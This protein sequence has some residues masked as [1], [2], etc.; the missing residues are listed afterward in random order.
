MNRKRFE[1][2]KETLHGSQVPHQTAMNIALELLEAIQKY[3]E[4]EQ[5]ENAKDKAV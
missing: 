1:D 4:K 5:E 3:I 2:I